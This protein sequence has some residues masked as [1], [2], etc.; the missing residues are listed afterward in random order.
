MNPVALID[1]IEPAPPAPVAVQ[2][3]W[4]AGSL[5][6]MGMLLVLGGVLWW[7]CRACRTARRCMRQLHQQHTSGALD[8]HAVGHQIA[9]VLRRHLRITQLQAA[10]IPVR[11]PAKAQPHWAALLIQLDRLRYQPEIALSE[12]QWAQLWTQLALCLTR[13][14]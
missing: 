5:L 8:A 7:R 2:S 4:L 6:L 13:C 11:L 14:G 1:I 12:A 3:H 9:E 10:V